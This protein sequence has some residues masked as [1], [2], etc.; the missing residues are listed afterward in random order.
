LSISEIEYCREGRHGVLHSGTTSYVRRNEA[1]FHDLGSE[2]V[3]S[4]F[5]NLVLLADKGSLGHP[6]S[7]VSIVTEKPVGCHRNHGSIFGWNKSL[8]DIQTSCGTD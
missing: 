5:T 8:K 2:D 6:L 3:N 7:Q 4:E 1:L